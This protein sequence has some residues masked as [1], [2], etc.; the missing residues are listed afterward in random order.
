MIG[1]RN[2]SQ[3]RIANALTKPLSIIMANT[4]SHPIYRPGDYVEG[5]VTINAPHT[6]DVTISD[7]H[8]S[9]RGV[10]KNP[11]NPAEKYA[12]L[13]QEDSSIKARL[14]QDHVF[15]EGSVNTYPFIFH[16]PED[17]PETL[18]SIAD[19]SQSTESL[20]YFVHAVLTPIQGAKENRDNGPWKIM[21]S[22]GSSIDTLSAACSQEIR[23]CA[24][25]G[26]PQPVKFEL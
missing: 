21:V 25:D 11:Q 5:F 23:V 22:G 15:H 17:L 2:S 14:P 26:T 9:L 19:E 4:A 13:L 8:I 18:H 1:S 12:F 24:A 6:N 3:T 20:E 7:L 10:K 16:L